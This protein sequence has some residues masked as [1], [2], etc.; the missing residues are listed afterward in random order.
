MLD[1]EKFLGTH[2]SN[3]LHMESQNENL[4]AHSPSKQA[5]SLGWGSPTGVSR[6]RSSNSIFVLRTQPASKT[7]PLVL[8]FTVTRVRFLLSDLQPA[9]HKEVG[10]LPEKPLQAPAKMPGKPALSPVAGMCW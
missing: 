3:D 4:R 2:I 5:Q 7:V 9:S 10:V 1:A 6:S 8:T